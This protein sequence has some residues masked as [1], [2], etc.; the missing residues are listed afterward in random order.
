MTLPENLPAALAE[1]LKKLAPGTYCTHRSW[2]FGKIK[3]WDVN[4]ESV[5][6]DFKSKAGHLMQFAYAAESLTP[7]APDHVS[8]QKAED[9][10][11]LKKK[12]HEDPVA[13]VTDCIRSLG[14]QATADNIQV[15]LSPEIIPAAEYKKWWEGA[16]RALKKNGHF[17]VPGKKTE[18]LRQLDA[19]SAMGD[20]ALENLRLAN[21]P[22]AILTALS[23]VSKYWPE[24][25][26]DSVLNEVAELLDATITKVPK[27]QLATQ[28]ELA[29]ARDEFFALA[30]GEPETGTWAVTTLAP[31]TAPGLSTLL[32]AL[33]GSRQPKLLEALKRGLPEAWPALFL[34]LIPRA[35]G[36]VAEVIT[37]AFQGAGRG[38]EVQ[39]AVNRYIRE[40]NITCDFLFWLCKNRPEIYGSLIEPQLFMAILS[41]LE[42]DQFSE[43]KKGTKLYELILGD[44]VLIAAILKDAPVADVRDITRAILL[45]PVF[46]EL[47]KRSLLAAIIKLYPDVQSMVVGSEKQA[48]NETKNEGKIIVSWPSLKR[49]EAELEDLDRN[50][51]PQNSKDI[52]IARGYGDLRENH[53]FKSAKEMQTILARRKAELESDL[54]RAEATDFANPDTSKV[55]L[56]T[57][58]TFKDISSGETHAYTILG[59]WDSD[60]SKGIISYETVVARALLNHTVGEQVELPGQ[61]GGNR[62][63]TI[64]KI[65]AH[66]VDLSIPHENN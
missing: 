45:S 11:A 7:L 12:A 46:E 32:D 14:V 3:D 25:K 51:I 63:V 61:D 18:A 47:D 20:S 16:K 34:G 6:I 8:V 62:Q 57:M 27:S 52:A 29:L 2:G 54:A 65:E 59:A 19:P 33:P 58:V 4:A 31:Q 44:K 37:E 24:I 50:Q 17:Y 30:G 22:K 48:S 60:L 56:G 66:Q 35:N 64:E 42:K 10:A 40:R 23:A 43:I 38:P 9:P 5:V 21:G 49:R 1:K 39:L 13:V 41:V 28:I 15:L 36:R 53:E 26:S 55:T